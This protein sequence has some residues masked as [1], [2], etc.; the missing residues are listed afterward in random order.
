M[1]PELSCFVGSTISLEMITCF[2]LFCFYEVT[3]TLIILYELSILFLGI[4]QR[5]IK[6][7]AHRG[8]STR[9]FIEVLTYNTSKLEESLIFIQR[10][11]DK[12]YACNGMLLIN[13]KNRQFILIQTT[14][15]RNIHWFSLIWNYRA[16]RGNL[17]NGKQISGHLGQCLGWGGGTHW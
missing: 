16:E 1:L 6:L 17:Y 2:V 7:Y 5:E 14:G 9:L 12:L 8:T 11:I 3:Q 10:W 13:R 4:Y 15:M